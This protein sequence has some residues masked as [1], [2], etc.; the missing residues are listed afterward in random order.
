MGAR[1]VVGAAAALSVSI[2]HTL[3]LG[4][5]AFAPLAAQIPAS[6]LALWSAAVPG[7]LM[8]LLARG[9]GVVYAPSTAVALLFGG[10][11]ALVM[12]AGAASGISAGQA[13][14]IAGMFAALGFLLQWVMAQLALARLARFIPVSVTQGFS[15]GVGLTLVLG[16]VQGLL[17]ISGFEWG[18]LLGWQLALAA[19]V[20]VLSHLLQLMWPR[21]PTL[22]LAVVLV[23]L[24]WF[25]WAPGVVV[26]QAAEPTG[27]TLPPVPEAAAAPWRVVLAQCGFQLAS[28]SL[29][30]A[31]VNSL[32]VL[33]FHQQLETEMGQR[34]FPEKVLAQEGLIGMVCALCGMI[35]A[36]T[37]T[38]R[39][40][41]ALSYTGVP[42]LRAGQWHALAL[43]GVATTG[44]FWLDRVPIAVL[45]G[46]L[47]IAGLRMVP[48]SMWGLHTEKHHRMALA[49]SWLVGLVFT[50][51]S[52]AMALLAGLAV[53]TAELLKTS[54]NHAVRRI[55]LQGKLRSRHMRRAE[56]EL[57]LAPRMET[58]AV[59]EL[60]GIVSFGVA[61]LVVDQVRQHLANHRCVILDAS[62][63]PS[64]DETGCL[65]LRA[66]A[67]ELHE[68]GVALVLSGV[69]GWVAQRMS[70]LHLHED[71]DRALEWAEEQILANHPSTMQGNDSAMSILGELG[72]EMQA[73]DRQMLEARMVLKHLEPG[74]TIIRQGE[75][76]RTL[77]LV[78]SGT[79]T[80]STTEV[81]NS[82]LRLAVIGAGAVFGEMAFLNGI[83][84][85]AYAHGGDEGATVSALSWDQFQDW[86]NVS[87][88]AAL[89]FVTA[90]AKMGIRRL[91]ATSQELRVAME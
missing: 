65:R 81:P 38:S 55:H 2:P 23:T 17:Q 68:Q 3:G 59:F 48:S 6:A 32:E 87:P 13:L 75:H 83:P 89:T 7:A 9:Q 30:M 16:Q 46:A 14:A 63:V 58:V 78:Q 25:F 42:S 88:A 74:E 77:F 79:V 21:F 69:R 90:L 54:G 26:A 61:A 60:Q 29:L 35:P 40:R 19:G 5:V 50:V 66:L 11:L 86:S 43:I 36:S 64:W 49:Q 53:A 47:V 31:V 1:P 33:V 15:A 80:L 28:L 70:D 41:M 27:F 76:D 18:S 52:G 45:I 51:S 24:F 20:A 44:H 73:N 39:S 8:T 4:L 67:H 56:V 82:G 62:R 10:M 12:Q 57:W 72:A 22:L 91:A 85:T 71:L 37:S 34:S 84:R